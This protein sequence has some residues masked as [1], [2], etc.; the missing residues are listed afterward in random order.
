MF[1]TQLISNSISSVWSSWVLSSAADKLLCLLSLS[2][3]TFYKYFLDHEP[4]I[5]S[6]LNME[7]Y[8]ILIWGFE[9]AKR[10][11]FVFSWCPENIMD[12]CFINFYG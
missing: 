6:A 9:T 3:S 7:K 5:W 12:H 10:F 4:M 2:H 11:L 1:Y 8:Y